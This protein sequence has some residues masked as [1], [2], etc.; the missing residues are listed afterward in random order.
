MSRECSEMTPYKSLFQEL[1]PGDISDTQ[2]EGIKTSKDI[3]E[4][5]IKFSLNNKYLSPLFSGTDEI[6]VNIDFKDFLVS[7]GDKT[8]EIEIDENLEIS[9]KEK[10]RT[11]T[12]FS[13]L[14]RDS[15]IELFSRVKA[16]CQLKTLSVIY[17]FMSLEE[18]SNLSK[19]DYYSKLLDS[20][21]EMRG[22]IFKFYPIKTVP[23][24]SDEDLIGLKL[25]QTYGD[26]YIDGNYYGVVLKTKSKEEPLRAFIYSLKN[27][28]FYRDLTKTISDSK[29][30]TN[31]DG[32]GF[33]IEPDKKNELMKRISNIENKF[34]KY[35][36][37][38]ERLYTKIITSLG[39]EMK[40]TDQFVLPRNEIKKLE[41]KFEETIE[42]KLS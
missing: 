8:Y 35:S 22:L 4:Y 23:K 17:P 29:L 27:K 1:G 25:D 9:F 26:L 12:G 39:L 10:G 40:G 19:P 3:F 38:R 31:E 37:I 32:Y 41:Q 2:L 11:V 24:L 33:F 13:E 15:L 34:S 14:D 16:V 21:E 7:V 42:R 20:K 36:R 28:L 18:I 5:K 30:K 6:R